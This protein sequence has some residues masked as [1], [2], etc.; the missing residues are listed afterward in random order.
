MA[1][2]RIPVGMIIHPQGAH[3][4]AYFEALA[5]TKEAES[6]FVVDP[7]GETEEKARKFLG[8]KFGGLFRD[9]ASMLQQAK[10]KMCLVSLEAVKTPPAI[11]AALNAGC[12]I[13]AEKP[14]CIRAE[15]FAPLVQKAD[16]KH[17][18]LMLALANRI[19][20][21]I[22]EARRVIRKGLLGQIYGVELHVIADQTRLKSPE[23]HQNWF[24]H[25]SRAGGGHLIWLGI[26]WLDLATHLTGMKI[27]EVAAMTQNVGGQP[28][29]V[30]D[31]ATVL[32]KFDNGS[33]GTMTSGYYL[34]KG[35]NMHI[36]IWGSCGWLQLGDLDTTPLV[37]YSTVDTK[38]PK[39]QKFEYPSG[40]R[41]YT[42]FVQAAVRAS[43]GL[44]DAP[45][46]GAE[47]LQVLRTIFGCYKAA[48]TGCRQKLG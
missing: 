17:L 32:M 37:Y 26:H 14:A 36:R 4:D 20:P 12:H 41:G 31:S 8:D 22:R 25:K 45:I 1:N 46:T 47:G 15:D 38:D 43:A 35:Y 39:E 27:T 42:P 28:I 13:L 19:T 40:Q 34:D 10:P 18:H 24:A 2:D 48:E 29:D 16:S 44:E 9:S 3:L 33:A 5:K 6:V 21:P 30:E 7:T 11:E 23:Y